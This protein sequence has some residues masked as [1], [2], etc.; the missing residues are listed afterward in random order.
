MT[1]RAYYR[2]DLALQQ[3]ETALRIFFE[4]A[5]FASVIT[6]AGAADEIFG[7]LLAADGRE[8]SLDI[9]KKAVV[10]IH[11]KLYDETI[12][13]SQIADR[14]NRARNSLK[15]WDRTQDLIVKLDLS[16]EATDMLSRA[17]DNYWAL[18]EELTPTMERFQREQ[19]AA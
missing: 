14:A 16:Q 8:N 15:H 9:I 2:D 3:L 18:K 12:E 11:R 6:L 1:V 4:G 10:A 13:P 7:K 17:I 5:D 19:Y